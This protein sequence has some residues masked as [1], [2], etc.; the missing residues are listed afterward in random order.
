MEKCCV[1]NSVDLMIKKNS[2]DFPTGIVVWLMVE[3]L[4]RPRHQ[5]SSTA[6]S[7]ANFSTC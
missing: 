3:M 1:S 2:V 5:C 6:Q 7:D 4:A